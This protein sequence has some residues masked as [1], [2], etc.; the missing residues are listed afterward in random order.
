MRR[1]FLIAQTHKEQKEPFRRVERRQRVF[2]EL[3]G[4]WSEGRQ[5][6]RRE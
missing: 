3:M 2:G 1:A 5:N 6:R 4:T